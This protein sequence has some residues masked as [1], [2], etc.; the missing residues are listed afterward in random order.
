MGGAVSLRLLLSLFRG[1][2][3]ALLLGRGRD[4]LGTGRAREV[5]AVDGGDVL[6]GKIGL[7]RI[8]MASGKW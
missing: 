7:G 5:Y 6:Q 3:L 1:L 2:C 8:L 4:S